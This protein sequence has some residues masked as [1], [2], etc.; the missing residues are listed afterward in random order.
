MRVIYGKTYKINK[1]IPKQSDADAMSMDPSTKRLYIVS[2]GKDVKMTYSTLS[3][4]DSTA[5]KKLPDIK[6]DGDTLEVMAL[7]ISSTRLFLNN[8]ANNQIEV[9][10]RD[11]ITIRATWP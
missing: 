10:D 7:E 6:V 9:I 8:S 11:K 2:G 3:V 4:V 1:S 5:G